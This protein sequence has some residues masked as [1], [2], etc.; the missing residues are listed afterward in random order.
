MFIL[1]EH[2]KCH[3]ICWNLKLYFIRKNNWLEFDAESDMPQN[4]YYY[5]V[6]FWI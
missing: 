4:P 1:N 5:K 2:C 6:I 3:E